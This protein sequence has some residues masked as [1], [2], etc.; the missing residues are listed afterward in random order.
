MLYIHC[1][2]HQWPSCGRQC[3]EHPSLCGICPWCS[4]RFLCSAAGKG[5]KK[6]KK[7]RDECARNCFS[8]ISHFSGMICRDV[9]LSLT[10]QSKPWGILGGCNHLQS[11]VISLRLGWKLQRISPNSLS[12]LGKNI[13]TSQKCSLRHFWHLKKKNL[14]IPSSL[15]SSRR[16]QEDHPSVWRKT[17]PEEKF[18]CAEELGCSL[19]VFKN[20]S[21]SS[22]TK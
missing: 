10:S 5:K 19:A 8:S 20:H 22:K 2:C 14:F 1:W 11:V 13:P 15:P 18:Q 7:R 3:P 12:D 6:S 16:K 4:Q 9:L 17:F 21:W